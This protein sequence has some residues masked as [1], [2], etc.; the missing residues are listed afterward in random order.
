MNTK[1]NEGEK[2]KLE[3]L[4]E[5]APKTATFIEG[6]VNSKGMEYA[7]LIHDIS[8]L[9]V[10]FVVDKELKELPKHELHTKALVLATEMKDRVNNAGITEISDLVAVLSDAESLVEIILED[11]IDT[12]PQTE[13]QN[14]H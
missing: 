9:K 5:I 10:Q 11:F 7:M 13:K 12:H 8:K 6:L 3:T 4:R 14:V 2:A 1:M